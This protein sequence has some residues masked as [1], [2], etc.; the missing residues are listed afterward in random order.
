VIRAGPRCELVARTEVGLF[1]NAEDVG[2]GKQCFSD[3]LWIE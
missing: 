2:G 1:E 3:Q